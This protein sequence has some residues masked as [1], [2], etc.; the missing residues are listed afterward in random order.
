MPSRLIQQESCEK[1]Y[2]LSL[3]KNAH[4]MRIHMISEVAS[5]EE[6][7]ILP[8]DGSPPVPCTP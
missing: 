8:F 3:T 6:Y 1:V 2:R 7:P 4:T 5:L